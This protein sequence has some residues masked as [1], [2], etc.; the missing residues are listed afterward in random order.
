MLINIVMD[1]GLQ[2]W[3]WDSLTVVQGMDFSFRSDA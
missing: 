1:A 2:W 3:R